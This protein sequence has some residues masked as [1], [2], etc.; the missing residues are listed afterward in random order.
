[1]NF[2]DI[3]CTVYSFHVFYW[4]SMENEVNNVCMSVKMIYVSDGISLT[5]DPELRCHGKKTC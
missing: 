5:L 1:M 3:G 2:R 4:E